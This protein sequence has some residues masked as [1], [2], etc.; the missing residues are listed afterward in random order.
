MALPLISMLSASQGHN[1]CLAEDPTV[2]RTPFL[3]TSLIHSWAMSS[4]VSPKCRKALSWVS[5]VTM[6]K[7][8]FNPW[9]TTKVSISHEVSLN[10][11]SV[12]S[13]ARQKQNSGLSSR[14]FLHCLVI[15]LSSLR[16]LFCKSSCWQQQ[17]SLT[18]LPCPALP[19]PV[20][21]PLVSTFPTRGTRVSWNLQLVSTA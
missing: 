5:L 4:D 8:P 21:M 16:V 13:A 7:Q 9:S 17:Q 2:E 10:F 18:S 1:L 6:S 15:L 11:V 12:C 14:P 19:C 3:R 20:Q